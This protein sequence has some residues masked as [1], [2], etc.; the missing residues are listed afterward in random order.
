MPLMKS[1]SREAISHNIKEMRKAGHSMAQ[2]IAASLSTARKY[3]K[4]AEGG[5]VMPDAIKK[6]AQ[7][8]MA[9]DPQMPNPLVEE[10]EERAD[11]HEAMGPDFSDDRDQ[12]ESGGAM[13][14]VSQSDVDRGSPEHKMDEDGMLSD[15]IMQILKKR[16]MKYSKE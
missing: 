8:E 12:V 16:K 11:S 7:P 2:S 6:L 13:K 1:G 4:M 14:P 10:G 9:T 15:E 3:K 5:M